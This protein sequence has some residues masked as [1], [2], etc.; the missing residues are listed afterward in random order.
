MKPR[1]TKKLAKESN[2]YKSYVLYYLEVKRILITYDQKWFKKTKYVWLSQYTA[3]IMQSFYWAGWTLFM[4]VGAKLEEI[5]KDSKTYKSLC[6]TTT[7][8][9][10][11]LK[12]SKQEEHFTLGLFLIKEILEYWLLFTV[13]VPG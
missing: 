6:G 3:A 7:T 5:I 8:Y 9:F 11:I 13:M 2:P 12:A 4:H 10:P 1:T